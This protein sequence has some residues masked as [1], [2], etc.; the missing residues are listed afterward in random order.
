M[1]QLISPSLSAVNTETK[2]KNFQIG[3]SGKCAF[4]GLINQEKCPFF[5]TKGNSCWDTK[6]NNDGYYLQID[7]DFS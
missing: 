7:V 1:I 4:S 2:T 6:G 3:K 5:D